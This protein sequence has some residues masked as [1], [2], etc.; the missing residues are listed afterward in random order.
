MVNMSKS[1]VEFKDSS[2]GVNEKIKRSNV[3]SANSSLLGF[4]ST[5]SQVQDNSSTS[6]VNSHCVIRVP[7][8][9][10][11]DTSAEERYDVASHSEPNS[12]IDAASNPSTA[13]ADAMKLK[14]EGIKRTT[15]TADKNDQTEQE[16]PIGDAMRALSKEEIA[17]LEE[18]F[19]VFDQNGEGTI[20]ASK[21]YRVMT[22]LIRDNPTEAE[23]QDLILANDADGK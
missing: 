6:S 5:L 13:P 15:S 1:L 12:F 11:G 22:S 21:L 18:S 10:L 7:K 14:P 19:A 8:L 16:R 20:N 2:H 17:D 9:K 3:T 4:S 23:V